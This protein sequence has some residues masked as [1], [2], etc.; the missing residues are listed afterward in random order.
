MMGISH[1]YVNDS[2]IDGDHAQITRKYYSW[3]NA[4]NLTC[5]HFNLHRQ[6]GQRHCV[7]GEN[8]K[9]HDKMW[10]HSEL[11]LSAELAIFMLKCNVCHAINPVS[12][13]VHETLL[14]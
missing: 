4:R 10:L 2:N 7:C 13:H 9:N 11:M 12:Y 8:F 1:Y 6:E 3:H 14:F 5:L